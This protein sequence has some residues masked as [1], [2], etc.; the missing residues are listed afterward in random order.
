MSSSQNRRPPAPSSSPN[1]GRRIGGPLHA[2][3]TPRRPLAEM[4]APNSSPSMFGDESPVCCDNEDDEQPR[5]KRLRT[6]TYSTP[7][8]DLAPLKRTSTREVDTESED[9]DDLP[10]PSVSRFRTNTSMR[11]LYRT[12]GTSRTFEKTHCG[13]VY[14]L[15][16][17]EEIFLIAYRLVVSSL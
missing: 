3:F 2:Y 5:R 17:V 4:S 16:Y 11:M 15:L 1:T 6:M 12:M 9:E 13:G 14:G 10:Q 7:K 8:L